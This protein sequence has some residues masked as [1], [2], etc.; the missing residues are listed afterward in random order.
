MATKY[1]E[2]QTL[3]YK[4]L[5]QTVTVEHVTPYHESDDPHAFVTVSLKN[6]D[7]RQVPV[8]S[9]DKFLTTDPPK[10]YSVLQLV[11]GKAKVKN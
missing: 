3:T 9:Q 1:R 11:T 5:N 10:R 7:L 2:G 8:K 4:P 6:G